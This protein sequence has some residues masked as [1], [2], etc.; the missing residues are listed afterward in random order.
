MKKLIQKLAVGIVTVTV[1]VGMMIP[2]MASNTSDHYI[3]SF[4]VPVSNVFTVYHTPREKQ[5]STPLYIKLTSTVHGN[6]KTQAR[7]MTYTAW[8]QETPSTLNTANLTA[9]SEGYGVTYVTLTPGIDYSLRSFV[10]EN[11]YAFAT[12]GFKA[13]YSNQSETVSGWWSPDSAYQHTYAD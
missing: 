9:N 2:T 1:I 4:S 5:D 3:D 6:V 11:G 10:Y 13:Y 8:M 7:G 12:F